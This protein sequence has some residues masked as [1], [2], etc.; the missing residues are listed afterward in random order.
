M[1]TL[2]ELAKSNK[3]RATGKRNSKGRPR[4]GSS[5]S[6]A[7]QAALAGPKAEDVKIAFPEDVK[8]T[9]VDPAAR[10]TG[11]PK[12]YPV[13]EKM[14]VV[15]T[16]KPAPPA[17]AAPPKPK[18]KP[19]PK[20][21]PAPPAAAPAP[22]PRP[23]PRPKPAA[24]PPPPPPPPAAAAR[25]LPHL[26]ARG[27]L[28]LAA[29]GALAGVGT[30]EWRRARAGRQLETASK[31]LGGLIAPKAARAGATAGQVKA[32]TL[33]EAYLANLARHLERKGATT[34]S[35]GVRK[36]DRDLEMPSWAGIGIPA[37]RINPISPLAM[38]A[39]GTIMMDSTAAVLGKKLTRRQRKAGA[40][41]VYDFA[42]ARGMLY[43]PLGAGRMVTG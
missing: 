2:V 36:D 21:R 8:L 3:R 40:S 37:S 5:T 17:A 39:S 12:P 32:S 23:K 10:P 19:K 22:R 28:G 27:A 42:G 1:S 13:P 38:L 6:A 30:Y 41:S 18:P 43:S 7:W 9:P 33:R 35:N 31:G 26:G 14:K 4:A 16:P 15:E 34:V 29:A 11:E 25:R 24:A 20:P